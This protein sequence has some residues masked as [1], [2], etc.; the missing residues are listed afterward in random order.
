MSFQFAASSFQTA[1]LGALNAKAESYLIEH[2]GDLPGQVRK[3]GPM[4]YSSPFGTEAII[5]ATDEYQAAGLDKQAKAMGLHLLARAAI[6]HG[7][8]KEAVQIATASDHLDNEHR[9][10]AANLTLKAYAMG[11]I[12]GQYN[13]A[14]EF[15]KSAEHLLRGSDQ[16]D[17]ASF[18]RSRL[19]RAE[20]YHRV[21]LANPAYLK[22]AIDMFEEGL[23]RVND[24]NAAFGKEERLKY[25][26]KLT[27]AFSKTLTQVARRNPTMIDATPCIRMAQSL[28]HS[29]LYMSDSLAGFDF[30][31]AAMKA[32][33]GDILAA[34]GRRDEAVAVLQTAL[35]DQKNAGAPVPRVA[36]T[37][38]KL[39]LAKGETD[40]R[41]GMGEVLARLAAFHGSDKHPSILRYRERLRAN[42]RPFPIFLPHQSM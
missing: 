31:R 41:G 34:V 36:A 33:H 24:E 2:L 21:G 30:E 27:A 35:N 23:A 17:D 22:N 8:S 16:W 13:M 29:A 6:R 12:D 5:L 18:V 26:A 32:T 42:A 3:T 14:N 4:E 40:T 9:L 11:M 20:V 10:H 28:I 39:H 7:Y 38:A 15:Y 37:E 19:N 25:K 1:T